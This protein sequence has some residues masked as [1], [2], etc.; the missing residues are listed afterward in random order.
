M[1]KIYIIKNENNNVEKF[2]ENIANSLHLSVD[3]LYDTNDYNSCEE[4][5]K[6]FIEWYFYDSV[7]SNLY[8]KYEYE[9]YNELFILACDV[10][11]DIGVI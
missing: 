7:Y 1:L 2:A 3:E 10:N 4:Y 6:D 9:I 11:E 8:Y 5:F